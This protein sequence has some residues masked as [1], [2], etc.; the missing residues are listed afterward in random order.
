[1]RRRRNNFKFTNKTHS[2]RGIRS[3]VLSTASIIV[4][5]Y[6]F[7]D[8]FRHKGQGSI[9]LGSGGFLMMIL[10]VIAFGWA[11]KSLGEEDSFKGIPVTAAILSFLAAGAWGTVYAAGFLF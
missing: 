2:R 9:Y 6:M 10:S 7:F 1:M 3:C 5:G 11:V 4:M 8:S